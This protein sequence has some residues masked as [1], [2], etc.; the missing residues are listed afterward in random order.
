MM[1]AVVGAM[2]NTGMDSARRAFVS[3]EIDRDVLTEMVGS[4][5]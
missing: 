2:A 1:S 4:V 3:N 5:V